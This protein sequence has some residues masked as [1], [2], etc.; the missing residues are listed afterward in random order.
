MA[1]L[2][3]FATTADA[4]EA[5]IAVPGP[6]EVPITFPNVA[7]PNPFRVQNTGI[8]PTPALPA[9]FAKESNLIITAA[10]IDF[11]GAAGLRP[12]VAPAFEAC[13]AFCEFGNQNITLSFN[14]FE[15]WLPCQ[16][17]IPPTAAIGVN[18]EPTWNGNPG[19]GGRCRIEYDSLNLQPIYAGALFSAVLSLEVEVA[20]NL[21]L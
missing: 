3:I 2:V 12:G 7:G 11:S 1:K 15:T 5:L 20:G 4:P 21:I 19:P 16:I 13:T 8:S 9:K 14:Q 10:R 17:I 6:R 18:L